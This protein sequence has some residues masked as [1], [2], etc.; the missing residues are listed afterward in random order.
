M[1][2][3]PSPR[4]ALAAATLMLVA[5]P[6]AAAATDAQLL[7]ALQRLTARVD[8]LE[9]RNAALEARLAAGASTTDAALASRV[10]V[11]EAEN[12]RLAA[13]LSSDRIS[14]REPELVTR[15]KAVESQNLS[16]RQQA[17]TIEALEGVTASA[18]VVAM[19]Q[20]ISGAGRLDGHPETLLNWR[21]DVSVTLPGGE[22]GNASGRFF[23]H[24]RLGE[25]DNFSDI[26]PMFT[27]ALNSTA[28]RLGN[29]DGQRD[30]ANSTALLAQA[31]Y[32]L[33]VPLP[34]GG[35]AEASRA[36]LEFNVGKM[37]PFVF[38]DQNAIAD[39]EAEKFV[40]NAFVHNPLLDSGHGA[41]VDD[42]G[43]SPGMRL[44]YHSDH[45]KPE[46]WRASVGVF[47]AGDGATFGRS[48]S[49]PFVIGQLEFGRKLFGGLDGNYRLYVWRNGQY[50]GFDGTVGRSSG[51]GLSVDQRVTDG[52]RLFAR[53][54]HAASGKVAFDHAVTVGGEIT[55]DPWGRGGDALGLAAGWLRAG[56][57]FRA[58]APL[59]PAFGY[60]PRGAEQIAE[61]YYRWRL[62]RQLALTPDLQYLRRAGADPDA[63][64][65][66]AFGVRA[67]YAF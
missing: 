37:D 30:R 61:L 62:N 29:P 50:Q 45:G 2:A 59:V 31:W 13:A 49:Q 24:V 17:R 28:F 51:W 41:G 48:L 6:T 57:A 3:F 27:G 25:G 1:A 44:A 58:E 23:A 53:Y 35:A 20:R 63:D 46:W 32:Q 36:H 5:G 55:G 26:R 4:A 12:R 7:Q 19:G 34:L 67:L 43:F 21:G 15:L 10:Q 65:V 54:G 9:Q 33:D 47:G 52:M 38:F 8:K 16:L 39:N 40:N 56:D 66:T 42:Y 11:L 60:A 22:L 64:N 18:S 14:E